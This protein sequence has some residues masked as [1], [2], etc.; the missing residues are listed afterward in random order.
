MK[1]TKKCR[2]VSEKG[3]VDENYNPSST[4]RSNEI[5]L[6]RDEKRD[7]KEREREK[8]RRK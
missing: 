5:R 1:K 7:N 3:F 2:K 4:E 6:L 8:E